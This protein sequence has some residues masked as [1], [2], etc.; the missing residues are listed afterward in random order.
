MKDLTTRLSAIAVEFGD[1]ADRFSGCAPVS[2]GSRRSPCDIARRLLDER[3]ARLDFFPS[4]LF[5]E[6]AWDML[7]AVYLAGEEGRIV[8]VKALVSTTNA[9]VTTSQRWID[10]L[11][12]LKLIERIVDPADRRR[13]EISLSDSGARAVIAYL[14]RVGG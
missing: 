11:H 4:E 2:D 13:V 12:K 6:P 5:H 7:L 9:P 1:R 10:H 8:N 14:D 3:Q